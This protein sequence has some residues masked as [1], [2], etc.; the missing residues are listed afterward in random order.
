MDKT[1]ARVVSN[2]FFHDLERQCRQL[3]LRRV[4]SMQRVQPRYVKLYHGR[5]LNDKDFAAEAERE[6]RIH[7]GILGNLYSGR[8]PLTREQSGLSLHINLEPFSVKLNKV[9][10]GSRAGTAALEDEELS[11]RATA[12]LMEMSARSTTLRTRVLPMA[13]SQH[14]IRRWLQRSCRNSTPSDMSLKLLKRDLR[15][16]AQMASSLSAA[17]TLGSNPEA[18]AHLYPE[19]LVPCGSGVFLGAVMASAINDGRCQNDIEVLHHPVRNMGARP[20]VLRRM[21]RQEKVSI[22]PIT[23]ISLRTFITWRQMGECQAETSLELASWYRDNMAMMEA[24]PFAL[25]GMLPTERVVDV[26]LARRLAD[27]K[28]RVQA[29]N[30]RQ[31]EIARFGWLDDMEEAA[32][33]LCAW[34]K[35][36]D[37]ACEFPND[38]SAPAEEQLPALMAAE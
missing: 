30:E 17:M 19:I 35:G 16:A 24:N 12:V 31:G 18:A 11:L 29:W 28:A 13:I 4:A 8:R 34:N 9:V 37:A 20:Q 7:Q 3:C 38:A 10:S 25:A 21:A 15:D 36:Q 14:A 23:L 5:L 22:E 27:L 1:L 6:E 26:D 2:R 33:E 32:P